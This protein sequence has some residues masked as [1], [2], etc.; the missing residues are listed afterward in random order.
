MTQ[1]E[2][3]EMLSLLKTAYPNFYSKMTKSNGEQMLNLWTEM[4]Q[5]ENFEIVKLALKELIETRTDFPPNIADV[6]IKIKEIQSALN[7]EPS[8]QE[9]WNIL[10][11]ALS[12]GLYGYTDEFEKL[13]PVLKNYIGYPAKLKELSTMDEEILNSVIYSQFLKNIKIEI[14]RE[15]R[16]SSL[17]AGVRELLEKAVKALPQ[18]GGAY[19]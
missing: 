17:P 12:N 7:R 4:F 14:E 10:K 5:F 8:N 6:K 15:K 11:K 18:V 3:I 2:V 16:V 13:P 9:L 19:E 1:K